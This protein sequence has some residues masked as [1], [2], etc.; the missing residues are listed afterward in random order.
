[1]K[2]TCSS[3]KILAFFATVLLALVATTQAFAQLTNGLVGYWPMDNVVG[4]NNQT[5]DVVNGYNLKACFGGGN[6]SGLFLT[7]FNGLLYLTNDAVRGNSVFYNGAAFTP[8]GTGGNGLNMYLAFQSV[9]TNDLVPVN[10]YSCNSNTVSFWFKAYGAAANWPAPNNDERVWTESDYIR[11]YASVF[12]LS[13][14][15]SGYDIF[16]RQT[17]PAAPADSPYGQFSG[18]A[19]TTLTDTIIDGT[20]HNVTIETQP[21]ATGTNTANYVTYI[22]G[23]VDPSSVGAAGLA[24]VNGLWKLDTLSLFA[25]ARNGAAGFVTND[26]AVDDLAEWARPLAPSEILDYMANGI[27]NVAGGVSP[28]TIS[29]FS[30]DLFS[31]VQGSS[32][33]LTWQVSSDATGISIDNGV[34]NVFPLST[35]GVGS[36]TVTVNGTTTYH[37][38]VTRGAQSTTSSITIQTISGVAAGWNYVGGFNE[39]T[40]GPLLNQGNWQTLLSSPQTAGYTTATVLQTVTGNQILGISGSTELSAGFYGSHGIGL[41]ATNTLF[42]R[43]YVAGG[44]GDTDPILTA[45]PDV[46]VNIGSSDAILRDLV[47]FTGTPPLSGGA[48]NTLGAGPGP[49]VRIFRDAGGAGGPVDL[50]A[51]FIDGTGTYQSYSYAASVDP[52][53]LATN[54]VYNVWIDVWNYSNNPA[55]ANGIGAANSYQVTV[56]K[57]G[58]AGTIIPLFSYVVSDRSTNSN[59]TLNEAF[60]CANTTPGQSTNNYV[61]L[62][63]FYVS[64]GGVNHTL[65]VPQGS[66][67]LGTPTSPLSI[68][69]TNV[70][71]TGNSVTLN[72]ST[73]PSTGAFTFTTYKSASLTSPFPSGWT[74][75]HTGISANTDTDSSATGAQQFYRVTSP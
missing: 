15:V 74:Q 35:C 55:G 1:M 41:N 62:D 39:N 60:V 42:F 51:N 6:A 61:R 65:P 64:S 21:T 33:K 67:I 26:C 28:V 40:A 70:S 24:K 43:F 9:N 38:T 37:L 56:Q 45:I 19:H 5:P 25:L 69:I 75:V 48:A 47:D 29:Q 52:T 71:K 72:W 13:P 68:K 49:A 32:V 18:G 73:V 57:G 36:T 3:N 4:C 8:G 59:E 44:I 50:T 12:D 2:R 11:T 10:R 46:D 54:T 63:D 34:G 14:T 23:V 16:L 53:G 58:D 17:P 31:V 7:N 27:T 22:D 20:W 30:S 66:F